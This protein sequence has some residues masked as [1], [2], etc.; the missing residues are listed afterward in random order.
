MISFAYRNILFVYLKIKINML[1]IMIMIDSSI[2]KNSV[3]DFSI[4]Q[5][6]INVSGN[7]CTKFHSVTFNKNVILAFIFVRISDLNVCIP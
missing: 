4:Y 6:G 3:R 2:H 5:R 1:T 7:P